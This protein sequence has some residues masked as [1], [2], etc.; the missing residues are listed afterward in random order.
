MCCLV[1]CL[2]STEKHRIYLQ[3]LKAVH[4]RHDQL[5]CNFRKQCVRQ[6]SSLGRL[7]SHVKESHSVIADLEKEK[8][9]VEDDVECRCDM[10]SCGGMKFKNTNLLLTHVNNYHITEERSCVFDQCDY[11]FSR[12]SRSRNHFLRQHTSVGN[13]ELKSKHLVVQ[14]SHVGTGSVVE[15]AMDESYIDFEEEI[16]EEG[17]ALLL[18][19][20]SE[21]TSNV[22]TSEG[23]VTDNF[24]QMQYADFLN[25]MCNVGFIPARK[26]TE[27][28]ENYLQNAL[29]SREIRKK[30]LLKS[31]DEIESLT[32]RQKEK[33]VKESIDD[34]EYLTAQ[35]DLCSD[36]KRNKFIRQNFKYVA[37]VQITLNSSEVSKGE[38]PDVFHYIPI[39]E[40]FRV[41]IEDKSFND[42]LEAQRD[43][44]GQCNKGVLRDLRDGEAFK[45]NTFFKE[46]PGAY[47]AL[48]YS[49]GV[50]L[51][52]PL[53]WAKGRHKIVQVF[54]TLC[55][56][57]RGQRSQIDRTQVC[58]IF[59]DKLVKKYGYDAIFRMLVND[60]KDLEI[61]IHV[62]YPV[63]RIVQLGVLAYSAD[64]LEA[65]QLGGF[66]CCFS[67]LDICRFC[68]CSHSEL[69]D[70]IHDFDGDSMKSY[71]TVQE[72]D[73]ICSKLEEDDGEEEEDQL[74]VDENNLLFQS[75]SQELQVFNDEEDLRSA[76][77]EEES[78]DVDDDGD[79]NDTGE[80]DENQETFGLKRRCPLNELQAFHAVTSF[81]P[82]CM[83]DWLEGALAQDLCGGIKILSLKGWFSLEEYNNRLKKFKFSSYEAND[84]PQEIGK[85]SKKLSGKACS[86]WVHARNFPLI[87]KD[88]IKDLDDEVLSFLLLLVDITARITA[89]EFRHH[90]IDN[91]EQEV[92]KYLN[93]RK[94]I[95]E[96]FPDCMGTPKPKHHFISHYGQAIRLYGPPLSYWT[97]RFESKHR[98]AKNVAESC[99]NFKNITLT[100][101]NR[102][103]MRMASVYY[104]VKIYQLFH[105][106]A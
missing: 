27:I 46:N 61:G 71:W 12:G 6:F 106:R 41:L 83:H 85:K 16:Y 91:L 67:S 28:A 86:L 90:E 69:L 29:K 66:S 97:A 94:D 43:D 14:V 53:G 13:M 52:N 84:K 70:N 92:L 65:H 18:D 60:L 48:F 32:V 20:D 23:S 1:G 105:H 38:S 63:Q 42:V 78:D 45:G 37:P 4:F 73:M 101:A 22:E 33:I 75:E 88:F 74:V 89:N 47:A 96:A 54:Y 35:K 3:H 17:D 26:I 62:S 19:I 25:R 31:L 93:D 68:H 11:R 44:S 76:M 15:A 7:L 40:S 82:D 99:K 59:K 95:H 39:K 77:N 79:D 98:I 34:D 55:Q 49:D 8:R 9:Q 87:V 5:I 80:I 24:F 30:R 2:F 50:E 72:Y 102:Q 56:I 104:Q 57:P 58:M 51:T 36:Y 64:N 100:V 103:Q 10:M 81:P 21:E